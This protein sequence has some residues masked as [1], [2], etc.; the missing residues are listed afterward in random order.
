MRTGQVAEELT[1]HPD[2]E[3]VIAPRI[4]PADESAH[5]FLSPT[6]NIVKSWD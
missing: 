5:P 6:H 3:T 1:V 4:A 2:L